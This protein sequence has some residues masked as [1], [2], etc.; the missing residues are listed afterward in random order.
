MSDA[1]RTFS[2]L[3]VDDEVLAQD[4]LAMHIER[5]PQLHVVGRCQTA[6]GAMDALRARQ[7]DLLFLD[8]RMPGITGLELLRSLAQPPLT[9]MTTA[10]AE[11]AV[12]GFELDVVDYLLKP[13]TFERF[14]KAANRALRLLDTQHQASPSPADERGRSMLVKVDQR[15]VKVELDRILF[16]EAMEKYVKIHLPEG[17]LVTLL[18]L[19]RMEEILP[20]ARFFRVHK[21]YIVNTEKVDA[22]AGNE[23]MIGGKAVPI[24]R[25]SKEVLRRMV[26]G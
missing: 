4:L 1:P 15:E 10:F 21:S 12:E 13:V 11:H 14:L 9:I 19:A 23:A 17:K 16:V 25:Q 7:V 8:I 3:L 26:G 18:S 22:I 5:V 24:A 6:A 2:C 20:P